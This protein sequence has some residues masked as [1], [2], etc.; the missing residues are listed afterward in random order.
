MTDMNPLKPIPF[1]MFGLQRSG[2]NLARLLLMRN[3]EV[4]SLERGGEWKH[5]HIAEAHRD[6]IHNGEPVR[7]I[8]CV[9]NP[10]AWLHS[11]YR[12]F[13]RSKGADRTVAKQFRKDWAF[14]D[15]VTGPTYHFSNPV[16]RWNEM[17]RHWITFPRRNQ[18]SEVILHESMLRPSQQE[19]VMADIEKRQGLIRQGEEISGAWRQVGVDMRRLG[20]FD[21]EYY[22]NREYLAH[23]TEDLL[24]FVNQQLDRE[25][26]QVFGYSFATRG[27]WSDVQARVAHKTG[28]LPHDGN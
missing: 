2:T 6:W 17:N 25:I 12:Y 16:A 7:L 10:Y 9:K 8:I 5:G 3:Y 1:K 13:L 19:I 27:E 11:C 15:F 23:F 28:N 20:A 21:V 24:S 22:E 18:Y 4:E 26:V 14:A